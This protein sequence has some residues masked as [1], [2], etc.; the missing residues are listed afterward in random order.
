MKPTYT[1]LTGKPVR[2]PASII[3]ATTGLRVAGP[4][5]EQLARAGSGIVTIRYLTN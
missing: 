2:K 3:D 1:D 5:D 4:T